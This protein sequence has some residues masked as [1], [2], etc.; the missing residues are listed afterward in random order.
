MKKIVKNQKGVT[1]TILM[2][3]IVVIAILTGIVIR[4]LDI[5]TDIRNYNYMKAD[6]ELLES[7]IL[8][9]YNENGTIPIIE[10]TIFNAKSTLGEQAN[11]KD[12]DNYYQIDISKITNVTL[13]YGGGTI[14][15][16]DVY[17][18]NEQSHSVYYLKGVVVEEQTRYRQ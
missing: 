18:I 12:N 7:K 1:L 11:S 17:I 3:V 5:G 4:N 8:T 9:Y 16:G 14:A 10:G 6:I 15:N 13:N 2:I